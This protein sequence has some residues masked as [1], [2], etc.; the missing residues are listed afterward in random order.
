[1]TLREEVEYINQ[2]LTETREKL[3]DLNFKFYS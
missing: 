2:E 3:K 1:M